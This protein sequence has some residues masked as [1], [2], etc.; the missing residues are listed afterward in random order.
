MYRVI[1]ILLIVVCSATSAGARHHRHRYHVFVPDS[2]LLLHNAPVTSRLESNQTER[3]SSEVE[4]PP[5]SSRDGARGVIPPDWKQ[6]PL[7]RR[8]VSL[9]RWLSIIRFLH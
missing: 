6:Q 5:V 7:D 3:S 1:L 8:S 9:A 4:R 2:Y